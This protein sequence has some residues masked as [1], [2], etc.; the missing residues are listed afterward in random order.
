M[1]NNVKS[2]C[3]ALVATAM[4]TVAAAMAKIS[5]KEYHVLQI[6]FFRQIVVF[7][8]CLPSIAGSFPQSLK[9]DNPLL[10]CVRL[11][12]AFTALAC[13]IW[14]V[15]VLPLTTAITLE[16]SQVFLIALLAFWFL[17]E[18]IGSHRITAIVI[19]FVGVVIA[20]RPGVD[21]LFNVHALIPFLGALGASIAV[22]SVRTLSQTDSTATLLIYQSVFVGALAGVPM[23]WLWKTPDNLGLVMLM[24]IGVL[25]TV[26]QWAGVVALRLGEASVIG[27]TK[28]MQIVYAAI[29]GFLIFQEVPD[30][31]TLIGAVCI[32]FSSLYMLH[33]E[34]LAK[35]RK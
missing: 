21:G 22:I 13:G 14:A 32:V 10:H 2:I 4:F 15:S 31:Y 35:S 12:G 9:T 18:S 23:F 16:F 8:S 27:N 24:S 20:S 26:G 34:R 28:C 25:A 30:I 7:V 11:G 33:R 6:L 17:N 1:T 29:L 5:V 3:W 19:G